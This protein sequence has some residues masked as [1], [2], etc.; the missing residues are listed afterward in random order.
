[1]VKSIMK[2]LFAKCVRVRDNGFEV[3]VQICQEVYHCSHPFSLVFISFHLDDVKEGAINLVLDCFL[4]HVG[5]HNGLTL[6]DG[7]GVGARCSKSNMVLEIKCCG[8]QCKLV[9]YLGF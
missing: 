1:M 2:L 5:G 8:I 3:V 6:G 9:N 7:R 4:Q